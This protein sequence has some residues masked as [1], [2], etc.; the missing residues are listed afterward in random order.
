MHRVASEQEILAASGELLFHADSTEA[1]AAAA[2]RILVPHTEALWASVELPRADGRFVAVAH[3]EPAMETVVRRVRLSPTDEQDPFALAVGRASATWLDAGEAAAVL[4]GLAAA[5]VLALPLGVPGRAAHGALILGFDAPPPPSNELF[6]QLAMRITAAISLAREIEAARSRHM[7]SLQALAMVAHDLRNPL[8][9]I[10]A[11]SAVIGMTVRGSAYAQ[12]VERSISAIDDAVRASG[13]MV[14]DLLDVATVEGGRLTVVRETV[15]L[16]ELVDDVVA[17]FA[18]EAGRAAVAL[19]TDIDPGLPP[20][21]CDPT[22]I[23]QVLTNL[24]GNS[25][26]FTPRGHGVT[27]RVRRKHSVVT[28]TV[29]DTGRGI[30]GEE[31]AQV[32]RPFWHKPQGGK[33]GHGLG[34]FITKA[35]VEAH[36]SALL[37]SSNPTGTTVEFALAVAATE[38]PTTA[39]AAGCGRGA[40]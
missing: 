22:R 9:T 7:P 37:I 18:M 1:V 21:S 10:A 24:V 28:L 12:G 31:L 32:T 2:V 5:G 26:K 34:L 29:R 15:H 19:T 23:R 33:G 6:L 17:T 27:V 8:S 20:V 25:L 36:G 38:A 16:P 3:R 30:S 14:G 40:S 35:I 4:P 11:S 39:G 13:R